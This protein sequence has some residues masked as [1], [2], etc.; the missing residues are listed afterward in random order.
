MYFHAG[1][2]YYPFAFLAKYV[3]TQDNFLHLVLVSL[4]INTDVLMKGFDNLR[5]HSVAPPQWMMRNVDDR[6]AS[7]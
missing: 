6:C 2:H 5:N 7:C 1:T 3:N 4:M